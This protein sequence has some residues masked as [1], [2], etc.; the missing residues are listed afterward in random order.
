[1]ARGEWFRDTPLSRW[2][3]EEVLAYWD[4]PWPWPA[5]TRDDAEWFSEEE[6][7]SYLRGYKEHATGSWLGAANPVPAAFTA[8]K[9]AEIAHL[10]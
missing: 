8:A 7:E 1:M 6:L 5:K 10:G 2:M 9:L 4:M 3:L